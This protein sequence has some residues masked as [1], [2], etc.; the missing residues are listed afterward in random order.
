MIEMLSW[1]LKYSDLLK[2]NLKL[3]IT[4]CDVINVFEKIIIAFFDTVTT[5]TPLGSDMKYVL[6]SM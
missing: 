5:G 1:Y 3:E 2:K 4:N 6:F